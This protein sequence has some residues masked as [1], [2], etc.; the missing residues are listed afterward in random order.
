MAQSVRVSDE[1]YQLAQRV[2][3]AAERSL[4]QQL[5]YWARLGAAIDA[6][7][8]SSEQVARLLGS[9]DAAAALRG[10]VYGRVLDQPDVNKKI[11]Q[12]WHSR[13]ERQVN[14]GRRSAQSLLAFDNEA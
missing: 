5:E 13:L 2:S 10:A 7:G 1:L 3:G 4:A 11:L 9:E 8:I 14:S 6:T 12:A